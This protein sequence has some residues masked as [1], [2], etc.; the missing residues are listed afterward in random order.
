MTAMKIGDRVRHKDEKKNKKY[1]L[2]EILDIKN[3]FAV[4]RSG[5]FNNLCVFT[6]PLSELRISA[7]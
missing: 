3:R 2:M 6:F 7:V 1:G 4:C 5:D